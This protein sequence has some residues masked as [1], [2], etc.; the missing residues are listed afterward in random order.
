MASSRRRPKRSGAPEHGKKK[1]KDPPGPDSHRGDAGE[2]FSAGGGPPAVYFEVLE[3][4]SCGK[5][6]HG[7]DNSGCP[8]LRA[9]ARRRGVTRQSSW[10]LHRGFGRPRTATRGGGREL[11]FRV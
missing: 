8:G 4:R 9:L 7:G 6:E 3:L 10:A 5:N 11:G 2:V 1:G